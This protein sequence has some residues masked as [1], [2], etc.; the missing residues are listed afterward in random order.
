MVVWRIFFIKCINAG[1][2]LTCWYTSIK[3]KQV[4]AYFSKV[5]GKTC[6]SRRQACL[7]S[8]SL[9]CTLCVRNHRG[10]VDKPLTL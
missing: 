8:K 4:G 1:V 9:L 7:S 6:H 10:V 2:S 5:E 3:Q